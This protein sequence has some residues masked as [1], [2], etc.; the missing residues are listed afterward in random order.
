MSATPIVYEL[1]AFTKRAASRLSV[2]ELIEAE[3]SIAHNP[4]AGDLLRGGGGARKLRWGTE[5][6]GKSGGVRLIYYFAGANG[7]IYMIDIYAKNEQANLS[8]QQLGLVHDICK[9]LAQG[10]SDG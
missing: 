2:D 10:D 6:R 7:R 8:K 4:T 9:T 1:R 5:S 3:A